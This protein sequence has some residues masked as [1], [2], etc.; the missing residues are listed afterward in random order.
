MKQFVYVKKDISHK[1]GIVKK[2]E[3]GIID[4]NCG[5]TKI[6]SFVCKCNY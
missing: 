5:T 2:N 4:E 6:V 3:I 1:T